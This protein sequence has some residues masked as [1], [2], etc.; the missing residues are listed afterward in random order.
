MYDPRVKKVRETLAEKN[1]DSLLVSN[2]Y[3]IFYLTGFKALTTDEREAFILITKNSVYLFSDE[4]YISKNFPA[5][6]AGRQLP[7]SNFQCRLIEPGKGLIFHLQEIIKSEQI[8]TLGFEAEDLKYSEYQKIKEFLGNVN[9]TSTDRLIITIREIKDQQE[10]DLVEK[11]CE[12]GD[13]CLS[14]I[15][16]IIKFGVSEKEIAFK[17]EMWIKEKG[18]DISFDPIVA[19]DANSAVAHYNTKTGEG[20]IKNGSV[21]LL[22]FGVKYKDYLS[23]MTRMVFFG[24]SNNEVENAYQVLLNAQEKTVE[25]VAD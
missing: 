3:N 21:I 18:Y 13:Q 4:R 24:K 15:I 14:D 10:I 22:D 19:I 11:A 8:K 25:K 9:L 1:I 7:I 5:S 23:D 6:P 2:F 16:K 12:I 20:K 17:M